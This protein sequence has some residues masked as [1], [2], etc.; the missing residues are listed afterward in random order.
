MT[1]DALSINDITDDLVISASDLKQSSVEQLFHAHHPRVCRIAYALCGREKSGRATVKR[2]M[3]KAFIALPKWES[4]ADASNWFLHHTILESRDGVASPPSA[5]DDCLIQ[6]MGRAAPEHDAFV[7]ALRNLP[8]QQQEAFLLSRCERLE[9]RQLA[10]AMDCSTNA[11]ANHLIA[12]NRDLGTIAAGAFDANIANLNRVYASLTPPED[13]IVGDVSVIGR[14]LARRR[15][16]RAI[17][18]LLVLVVLAAAGW[19][20]WRLSQMIDI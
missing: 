5:S 10:V 3:K 11:A 9:P 13:L 20:A 15:F 19:A 17:M 6:R 1:T 14:K 2:V 12:A 8:P 18:F 4:A 16:R 7:R